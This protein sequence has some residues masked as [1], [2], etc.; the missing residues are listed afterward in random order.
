M[1]IKVRDTLAGLVS[2][3]INANNADEQRMTRA[4]L[5]KPRIRAALHLEVPAK[6]S[7]LRPSPIDPVAV[8]Q[9]LK[10][11]IRSIDPHPVVVDRKRPAVPS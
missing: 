11:L 4:L 3:G 5:Q 10:Q 2:A 6:Q 1:A 9:K 8:Q 7:R